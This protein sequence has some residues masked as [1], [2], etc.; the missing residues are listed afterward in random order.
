[1]TGMPYPFVAMFVAAAAG[2][3][4]R[5]HRVV[6]LADRLR[7]S[8]RARTLNSIGVSLLSAVLLVWT[9]L[10]IY[11]IKT[12]GDETAVLAFS[13][14]NVVTKMTITPRTDGDYGLRATISSTLIVGIFD[15]VL[16]GIACAIARL[17]EGTRRKIYAGMFFLGRDR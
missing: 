15:G 11:N 8:R 12:D 14:G 6:A 1:M 2:V 4:H 10:P 16:I 3:L 9:S 5:V 17:P 7:R 13:F